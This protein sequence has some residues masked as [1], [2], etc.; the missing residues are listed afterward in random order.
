[1]TSMEMMFRATQ[2]GVRSDDRYEGRMGRMIGFTP[3]Y[4]LIFMYLVIR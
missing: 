2:A 4:A 3:M 1:M